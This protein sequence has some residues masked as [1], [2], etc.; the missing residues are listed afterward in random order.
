MGEERRVYCKFCEQTFITD[1]LDRC[2]LCRKTGGLLDPMSP[3]ALTDMV[4]KKRELTDP[5]NQLRKGL[6]TGVNII[7]LVGQLFFYIA[8]GILATVIGGLII[9][10]LVFRANLEQ[11]SLMDAILGFGATAVGLLF[12]LLAYLA[13]RGAKKDAATRVAE[14]SKES[15]VGRESGLQT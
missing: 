7:L 10:N 8:A 15:G 4:T 1:E 3:G 14:K 9:F 6:E 12:F 11:W 13:W 2:S 5:A